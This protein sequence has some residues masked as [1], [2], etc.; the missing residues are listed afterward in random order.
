MFSCLITFSMAITQSTRQYDRCLLFLLVFN[1]FS[2]LWTRSGI[3]T[4]IVVI[5]WYTLILNSPLISYSGKFGGRKDEF[6]KWLVICQSFN[7]N[8]SSVLLC[9][10]QIFP[11]SNFY[12]LWQQQ[13]LLRWQPQIRYNGHEW[14]MYIS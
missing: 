7:T 13:D 11:L 3:Y 6:N 4:Y 2:S 12:S 14:S 1:R 10:Y 9:I 8:H 5:I